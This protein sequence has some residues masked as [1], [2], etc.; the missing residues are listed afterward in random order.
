[1]TTES[2]DERRAANKAKRK[3]MVTEAKR[4][5]ALAWLD[6]ACDCPNESWSLA[7]RLRNAMR[8]LDYEEG[9]PALDYFITLVMDAHIKEGTDD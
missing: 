4:E 6:V 1:M 7:C 2:D 5:A 3:S 9:C 8:G